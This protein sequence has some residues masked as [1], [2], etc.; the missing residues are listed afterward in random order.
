MSDKRL[1]AQP[2]DADERDVVKLRSNYRGEDVYVYR[3]DLRPKDPNGSC[4]AIWRRSMSFTKSP[5]GTMH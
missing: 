5:S 1:P 3:F 4:A 2:V